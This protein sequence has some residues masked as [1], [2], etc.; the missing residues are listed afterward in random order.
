MQSGTEYPSKVPGVSAKPA[1]QSF[2][3]YINPAA[4]Q[5]Q[6]KWTLGNARNPEIQG[7]RS[8]DVDAGLDKT[9]SLMEG[10]KLQFRVEAFNLTNTPNW[11]F[12]GGGGP[13]GPGG[14][15]P[16][17][18]GPGGPG[19]PGGGGGPTSIG[20]Y[21]PATGPC[22]NGPGGTA[23]VAGDIGTSAGGFGSITNAS[24]QRIL[25]FALRLTF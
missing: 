17:G 1:H 14:P 24:G 2:A 15:P 3:N 21:C 11:A 4:F 10:F 8:R 16:G 9:F 23:N 19:G 25:Q 12:G 6:P 22:T 7:P 18:G 5:L 20:T 13:G